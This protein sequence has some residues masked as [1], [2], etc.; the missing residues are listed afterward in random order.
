M[1]KRARPYGNNASV[2]GMGMSMV[3]RSSARRGDRDFVISLVLASFLAMA[4]YPYLGSGL[5]LYL[6]LSLALVLAG[7]I[8]RVVFSSAIFL[9]VFISTITVHLKTNWGLSFLE[10]RIEVALIA[11]GFEVAEYIRSYLGLTDA[12]LLA[13]NILSLFFCFRAV[14]RF[15]DRSLLLHTVSLAI[16]VPIATTLLVAKPHRIPG[17]F[18]VKF[19]T[20]T[21][22]TVLR[23]NKVGSRHIAGQTLEAGSSCGTGPHNTVVVVLGEAVLKDRMSIYGYSKPTTPFLESIDPFVFDAISPANQTRFSVPMLFTSATASD[24][25]PFYHSPSI[26]TRLKNCGFDTYWISNQGRAG[27]YETNITTIAME[28]DHTVF[29]NNLGYQQSGYDGDIV[30]Q[31]VEVV[32]TGSA[33]R[34]IFVHLIGSHAAYDR[35]YPKDFALLSELDVDSHYDNSIY[36]TDHVLSEIYDTF[37][38]DDLLFVYL[39]DHGEV[40]DNDEFGHGFYPSYRDEFRIPL[41]VWSKHEE[42]PSKVMASSMGRVINAESFDHLLAYLLGLDKDAGLSYSGSVFSLDPKKQDGL[43]QLE[44]PSR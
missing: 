1:S 5:K 25:A 7:M 15:K 9:L 10:S 21:Y 37:R 19:V 22:E 34:A 39:S 40:V 29:V 4:P 11:P 33:K 43:R 32:D 30:K 12:L 38:S 6:V 24:F 14:G 17:F 3:N 27:R 23:L 36:Y 18:P 26:I 31:L 35:R 2:L 41:I 16:L 8:S 28:A 44:R 20:I 42:L 13:C